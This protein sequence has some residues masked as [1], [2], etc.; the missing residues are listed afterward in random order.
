MQYGARGWMR[1]LCGAVCLCLAGCGRWDDSAEESIEE[2]DQ[3]AEATEIPRAD[4]GTSAPRSVAES[5]AAPTN[6][7]ARAVAATLV[8]TV[9][10]QLGQESPD[11]RVN[12]RSILET[13]M[14]ISPEE[15]E[16]QTGNTLPAS[17]PGG[18]TPYRVRYHRVRLLQ[19]LPDQPQITYDS[20]AAT[21]S[22]PP[23]AR[24]YQ[25]LKDNGFR[26]RLNR[27]HQLTEVT[28][29]EPF[30]DRC[31]QPVP[32]EQRPQL[33][34]ALPLNSPA[35]VIAYFVDD[36]IGLLPPAVSQAGDSWLRSREILQ[37]V[38][39]VI[40]TRCT[41][42][43]MTAESVEV[44]MSGTLGPAA[45]RPE[46]DVAAIGGGRML[47]R[48][49]KL[50]GKCRLDR[51][52]GL[53]TYSHSEQS[54]E[55]VVRLADGTELQQFKTTVTTLEPRTGEASPFPPPASVSQK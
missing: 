11:G 53:P 42:R 48:G 17:S 51:R 32:K 41:I 38:P 24:L 21:G 27:E 9:V 18:Q 34:A 29:L 23:A 10:Q 7:A 14:T 43:Q 45:D 37:P 15:T 3:F 4:N 47:V 8:K 6:P 16:A 28:D 49:G 35:A 5:A 25:G 2:T 13:T 50:L 40:T 44:D 39:I 22:V 55:M 20:D 31:L 54:L 1:I 52:S 46:A 19:E 12:S 30:L 36:T 26:F 33:R